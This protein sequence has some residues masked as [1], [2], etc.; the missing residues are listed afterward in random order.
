MKF[1]KTIILLF[2]TVCFNWAYAAII[3]IQ[4]QNFNFSPQ[5]VDVSV[6]DTIQWNW[7][8]GTHTTTSVTVPTGAATWN[9]PMN[10]TNP[11]FTY[12]VT[13]PGT[14]T[15]QC[16]IH[17]AM[18]MTGTITVNPIGI[19]PIS[20]IV[21]DKFK[22][23]QNYP[24]PFNPSTNIKFDIPVRSNVTLVVYNMAGQ[25]V[26]QLVNEKLQAGTYSVN[27]D[28]GNNASGVYFYKLETSEFTLTKKLALLK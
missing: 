3:P 10:S 9:M 21:P 15:Y 19:R 20:T 5:T 8:A 12:V 27:W 14:Y 23:Y 1:K 22:L 7:V 17:A 11:T 2:M 24:N 16:N 25:T 6:N 13:V 26:I 4:I 28:A 18:G